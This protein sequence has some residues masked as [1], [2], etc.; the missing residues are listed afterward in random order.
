MERTAHTPNSRHMKQKSHVIHTNNKTKHSS[1]ISACLYHFTSVG[2][3]YQILQTGL[4]LSDG[5]NWKDKND[6]YGIDI[7][8]EYQNGNNVLVLCFCN[9]RGNVFL[10]NDKEYSPTIQLKD[11]RCCIKFKKNALSKHIKTIAGVKQPRL[12][13]YCSNEDVL[14]SQYAIEDIPYLK[15][16]EYEIEHEVRIIYIGLEKEKFIPN[17]NDCIS[18]IT[19]E[20]N[21]KDVLRQLQTELR[22]PK[23]NAAHI[24]IK[25]NGYKNSSIWK[26]NIKALSNYRK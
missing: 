24:K 1:I 12:I 14:N 2:N 26:N 11:Y 18:E 7:Y 9:N 22:N 17:I 3:L 13:E 15:R 20:T 5:K 25:T 21:R 4:K 8:R 19:I 10:W 23:Y 16:K 6:L